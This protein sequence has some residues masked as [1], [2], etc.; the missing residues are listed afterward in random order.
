M[1][2]AEFF[3]PHGHCYL[4]KPELV[5]LHIVSDAL[6]ALAYYSIPLTL[7]YFVAK[8]QDVPFNWIFLMFGAFIVSCGTGHVMDIWTLWHPNYWLSGFLKAFT[9]LVSIYTAFELVSLL[10][11][12]LAMP[13]AA[14]FEAVKTEIK[15]RQRAEAALLREKTHL[16]LAQKVAHVGSWEFDLATQE[17]AWSDETFRIYGFHPEQPT[18]TITEHLQNIHPDDRTIWDTAVNQLLKGKSW[19]LEYRIVRPDG[20]IRH[21]LGQG[22]PIFNSDSQV[23]KLFGTVVDITERKL[24]EQAQARLTAI[25]EA[26]PDIV[27][28]CDATG[29]KIYINPAARQFHGIEPDGDITNHQISEC[30]PKEVADFILEVAMPAAIANGIWKGET[31]WRRWDGEVFPVSQVIIAH[32]SERGEVEYISTIARDI[33]ELKRTEAALQ[34]QLAAVE[35]AR[36]GIAIVDSAQEYMY[37]N[38]AHIELYGYD[39][40]SQLLGKTWRELYYPDEIRRF[41][42][43]IFPILSRQG[44]WYGEAIGKRRD[45]STYFQEISLTLTAD[46]G[47]ICVCRDI[48][49]RKQVESA[50]KESEE[51]FRQVAENIHQVFWMVSA[52]Y[53]QML[54]VSPAY[55][56]IWQRSCQSLYEDLSSWFEAIHPEDQKRVL[57]TLP[58]ASQENYNLE[59]RIVRPDGSIRWIESHGFLICD[60]QGE[61]YRVAGISEDITERKLAEAEIIRSKDLL[62]SIFNESAD[63]LFLVNTETLLIADC[64][65]RAVE[66][67]EATSKDELLNIQGHTLQKQSFTPEQLSCIV[68]QLKLKGFWSLELEYVTKKGKLF[69]GNLAAKPI[70]VAG[71]NINLVRVTDITDRKRAEEALRESLQ[72]ERAIARAIQRMR[73]TLDIET[74]FTATTSELRQLIKCDRVAVYR[75]NPDWSGEFVSESV[76]ADW[77]S[78]VQEQ[79]NNSNLKESSLEDKHC[80]V[81]TFDSKAGC[82]NVLGVSSLVQDTYLQETRGGAYSQG[83]SYRVVQDIYKAGFNSCYINL[84]EGFQARAYIIVPIFCGSKLWGLLAT[85]QNSGSRQWKAAEIKLVVEIGN[86][87]GVALQQAEL[88]AQIQKQ[89]EALRQSSQREREKA[90]ELELTLGELRRTQAQLIQTEKMSSLGQMVAGVAHEINNPVSFIQCN[91]TP[92][93]EYF[94]DLL[95]LIELYQ[96]TYPNPTPDIQQ[97]ASEIDL[98]FL[99]EDWSKLMDSMQ[100]GA[101]RIEEIVRSL[102][103]FSRL[104]ES[105]LKPVDIHEGIEN[106]LFILQ[107]RLRAEGVSV[108]HSDSEQGASVGKGSVLRPE[109]KV[110]K[111]Y[112]QLPLV[113]CYA[114]QLNQVFMNLLSNAIDALE[115]QAT[116]RVITIRTRVV[117]RPEQR[118][119]DN[120]QR[121]TDFVVIRIADNGPGMSEKVRQKIFD[122]FFTTKPIGS[123]RGLGLSISYQ[124]VVDKHGGQLTCDSVPGQGAEFVIKLPSIQGKTSDIDSANDSMTA[125]RPTL[126]LQFQST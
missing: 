18:P 124:I 33:S 51:R 125:K 32:N 95:R 118:T 126:S 123:G 107:H 66:L 74:I 37:L 68:D 69:W 89:S 110:I 24:A 67:F 113:T 75:F 35:A 115:T 31:L 12:A 93:R 104:D 80:A 36:D 15:E 103:N 20:S 72:R 117:R 19:E 85:Y 50:L 109:I 100:V 25:L 121:T 48:T 112:G 26:T 102:R 21:L 45:G 6:T 101:E 92:A 23:E 82:D 22:Q 90:Q 5:G 79:A 11:Q 78:L 55:E 106:T 76:G 47:L 52:D 62:A 99:V 2:L 53:R 28:I 91:L 49:Q 39:S 30:H 14:Q 114:S 46:G 44:H 38:K 97:L 9:A 42:Q 122:P 34:R 98:D 83:A 58:L 63:A 8:R 16:A 105:E 10:P 116:P 13:S 7:S 86:Q 43:D 41:E 29:R 111:D 73:Q 59:Y 120:G 1:I 27:G 40:N 119:T 70:N 65:Q 17:F 3:I 57:A 84:L 54:Y 94:Q 71:Q 64:N 96:Q 61:V 88:L 81:K 87:L 56:D 77:I 60:E 108:A 4:W